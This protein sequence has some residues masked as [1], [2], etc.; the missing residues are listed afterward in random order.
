MSQD[1]RL[2]MPQLCSG[3]LLS[4]GAWS[5]LDG[6]PLPSISQGLSP[7]KTLELHKGMGC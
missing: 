4:L 2:W 5:V 7:H 3:L 1:P 6:A